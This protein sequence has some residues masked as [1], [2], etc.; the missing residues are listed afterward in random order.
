MSPSRCRTPPAPRRAAV[1]GPSRRSR[2]RDRRCAEALDRFG[3]RRKSRRRM[4]SEPHRRRQ[5]TGLLRHRGACGRRRPSLGSRRRRRPIRR[6][7][8]AAP[9]PRHRRRARSRPR[10]SC[11]P[12]WRQAGHNSHAC[13]RRRTG[14]SRSASGSWR[15]ARNPRRGRRF[16]TR[17]QGRLQ[18]PPSFDESCPAIRCTE[19]LVV[20][21]NSRHMGTRSS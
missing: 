15:T 20:G 5:T 3:S 11:A 10:V 6:G 8:R 21:Y 12:A 19:S 4:T 17:K 7:R 13:T 18:C 2:R 16:G 9:T 1:S 14:A